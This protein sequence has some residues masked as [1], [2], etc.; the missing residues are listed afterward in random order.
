MKM[1]GKL[2]VFVSIPQGTAVFQTFID[3]KV[4]E[5]LEERFDVRYLQFD[6]QLKK[7]EI[8]EYVSDAEVIITGWG[9]CQMDAECLKETNIRLVAHTGGSVGSLVTPDLYDAGVKVIS[10]ND[11]YADSVAEGVLAYMMTMLRKIPDYCA[12][13]R[14]GGWRPEGMVNEGL[15]DQTIGIIGMG[16]ISSRVIKLLQPF[17]VSVKIYSGYP[18]DESFLTENHAQQVSLE[19]I[20]ATCKIVSLH[21]A[22]NER[23]RGMIGKEHFD[24]L[25]DGS[26]FLNTARGKIIREEEMIE[27]L[28]ENR[29]RAMLDVYCEEPIASDSP[30]RSLP[31]VYC[32]PHA[33]GPTVDRRPVITMRL[34]DDMM[35]FREGK[36]LTMEID[37]EYAA[38]MTVGG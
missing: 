28:K 6:R 3:T 1:N 2:K 37:K 17:H 24:L 32:M 19:E 25:Q 18:V 31:N 26:F 35:R 15:L 23:T 8:A 5:Y 9:H 12:S 34:A 22:M 7:E 14:N 16:A 38:R 20:F 29:F 33:A 36:T 13:I 4:Q 30:L 21:S 11:M 27:A 10:G